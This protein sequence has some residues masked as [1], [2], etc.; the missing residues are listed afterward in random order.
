MN[1]RP[2]TPTLFLNVVIRRHLW[3]PMIR[4]ESDSLAGQC[5]DEDLHAITETEDGIQSERRETVRSYSTYLSEEC[6]PFG[7]Y[8]PRA[9]GHP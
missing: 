2:R 1:M 3:C 8:N 5:L 6:S 4:L 9:Y 7:C